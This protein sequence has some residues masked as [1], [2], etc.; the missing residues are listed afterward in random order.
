MSSNPLD[1]KINSNSPSKFGKRQDNNSLDYMTRLKDLTSGEYDK[2]SLL[3]KKNFVGVVL[4][5]ENSAEEGFEPGSM[6]QKKYAG[7]GSPPNLSSIKVRIPELHYMIP[8]PNDLGPEDCQKGQKCHHPII[9]MYPTFYAKSEVVPSPNPG[10]L[11]RVAYRDLDNF[12]DPI[13][14]AV[15]NQLGYYSA[16]LDASGASTMAGAVSGP[17]GAAPKPTGKV[18]AP[19]RKCQALRRFYNGPNEIGT[20]K[21]MKAEGGTAPGYRRGFKKTW[22][23]IHNMLLLA[24]KGSGISLPYI[25][26]KF[27]QDTGSPH[28]PVG[29]DRTKGSY[30]FPIRVKGIG[31]AIHI[32]THYNHK[33]PNTGLDVAMLASDVAKIQ[34]I[35][36][37]GGSSMPSS[38]KPSP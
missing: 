21:F 23:C 27:K 8:N 2:D 19:P 36:K 18:V 28:K 16:G 37:P 22:P 15:E 11:V 33:V 31:Y 30:W 38:S 1:I 4:R 6:P 34:A 26:N 14:L 25:K 3:D 32:S 29:P 9:D 24:W 10:D 13:Y 7:K 5:V 17:A 35:L 20:R 12:K